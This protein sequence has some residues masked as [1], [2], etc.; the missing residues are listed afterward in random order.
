MG[1]FTALADLGAGV[2]PMIMGLILEKTNY[3]VMFSC[4]I[5][6]GI[7]NFLYFYYVFCRKAGSPMMH[8]FTKEGISQIGQ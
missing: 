3:P 7:V 6:T 4:L 5:L 1:T 2:G 8:E